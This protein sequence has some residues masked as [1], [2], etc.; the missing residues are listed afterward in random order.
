MIFGEA[1]VLDP[2]A[3]ISRG[4]IIA[5]TSVDVFV[6]HKK[7]IQ[8]FQIDDAF[9]E[10]VKGKPSPIHLNCIGNHCY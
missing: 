4:S 7:Q 2:E 8:T 1:C 3:G 9:L 10:R 6:L 5:D